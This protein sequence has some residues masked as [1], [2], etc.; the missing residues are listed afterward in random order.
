MAWTAPATAV[1]GG[2]FGS[3]LF[4]TTVRD[5]LNETSTAKATQVSSWFPASGTNALAE[6]LPAQ[7]NDQGSSTTTSTSYVNLADGLTTAVSVATG[8]RAL[9]SI[10]ANFS[11][12]PGS[13]PNRSWVA[14]EISGATTVAAS[15]ISSI[16]H[17]F[18]GGM[19]WGASFLVTS[20]TPGTNTFTLRYRVSG[21]TGTFS[22]RRIAVIPF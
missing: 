11:N 8:N 7:D 22:V 20:L 9:V 14:F 4:N 16:N 18:N 10:Y 2:A 12:N 21:G 5:N 15:D 13:H 17:S 19:R 6:R 1:A 3:A